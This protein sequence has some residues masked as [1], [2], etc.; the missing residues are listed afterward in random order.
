MKLTE[1]TKIFDGVDAQEFDM[2][3]LIKHL[4]II[5]LPLAI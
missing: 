1:D 3:Y 5:L 4:I 2:E